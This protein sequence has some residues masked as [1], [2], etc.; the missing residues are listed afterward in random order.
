MPNGSAACVAAADTAGFCE[1][2]SSERGCRS[3]LTIIGV[4]TAALSEESQAKVF[5]FF[6][7]KMS[8]SYGNGRKAGLAAAKRGTASVVK[9]ER[10]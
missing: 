10:A 3:G 4:L 6:D 1:T 2:D 5:A 7:R 9:T 8:S